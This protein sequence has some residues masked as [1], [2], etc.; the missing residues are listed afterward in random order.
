MAIRKSELNSSLWAS[1]DENDIEIYN[2]FHLKYKSNNP[3]SKLLLKE[4][5]NKVNNHLQR[6][7]L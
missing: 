1:C 6:R 5:Y 4:F 3:I 7:W 2:E